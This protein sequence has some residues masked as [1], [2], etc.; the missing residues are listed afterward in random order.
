MAQ[1][2]KESAISRSAILFATLALVCQAAPRA[3][4]AQIERP[5]RWRLTVKQ[6][7][8]AGIAAHIAATIPEGWY[9]YGMDEPAGGPVPLLVT[10]VGDGTRLR[11]A[12]TALEPERRPDRNFNIMSLVYRD[13]AWLNFVVD[14]VRGGML[15]VGVRFQTCTDRYCLPARTDTV[16]A[17]VTFATAAAAAAAPAAKHESV[18]AVPAPAAVTQ[19]AVAPEAVAPAVAA[20]APGARAPSPTAG[21][22]AGLA[23]FLWLAA[24]T[25]L[26]A[27]LT[28]CVLPMVPITVGF[29]TRRGAEAKSGAVRD[30]AIFAAGIVASF[31]ALGFGVATIFGASRIVLLAANPLLNLVVAALFL[32]FAVQL[33][34]WWTVP[35]PSALLTRLTAAA[36]RGRG[37]GSLLLMGATF[38]LT[39]FTC[40][41]P[42]VGSLLVLASRGSRMWPLLGLVAYATVF[43]LPFFLL[44][45]FPA[46]AAKL[47]RSG[48]WLSTL[49]G[50][51]A[52]IELAAVV[53]FVSNA[54]MVWDWPF[55]T[56]SLVLW[57]WLA[58]AAALLV[59]LARDSVMN[60]RSNR[61]RPSAARVGG[62]LVTALVLASLARGLTGE[63][64]G[65][66]E[67]YLPPPRG[68]SGARAVN[69]L[70]WRLNAFDES[71]RRASEAGVP[72]LVDF[73]GYTCTNCRWMEA[74][75]FTKPSVR[76]ALAKFERARLY[77][78]GDGPAYASQQ[79]LQQRLTGSVALPYYVIVDPAGRVLGSFLGMTRDEGEFLAF[80]ADPKHLR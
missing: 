37:V 32:W 57:C 20:S 30:G 41:A 58:I 60:W 22:S 63:P 18:L 25:G 28:P 44:A 8:K 62:A 59:W 65:E 16:D 15:R 21:D 64:L 10:L 54:G 77:T 12:I 48:A 11:G 6:T 27:L 53:K 42:F 29:F 33:A 47:P 56:R 74:N 76:S 39:S 45:V 66:I 17:S 19:P 26:L 75:L 5:V 36:G 78:D 31:A 70:A 61:L 4:L 1:L 38:S 50:V 49:K 13:S 7:A 35:L 34:G 14:G 69:E 23:A 52:F 51:I 80:L 71:L 2:C 55:V 43:A 24:S 79:Q 73:T 68:D 9:V 40:T 46:A 67:A 3:A 72:V